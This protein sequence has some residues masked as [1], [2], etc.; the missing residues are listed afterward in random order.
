MPRP[1]MFRAIA[2]ESALAR[3]VEHERTTRG[4]SYEGLAARMTQVGCPLQA[5]AIYK[6]EKGEP[7]RRITVDELAAFALVFEMDLAEMLVMPNDADKARR[8]AEWGQILHHSINSDDALQ[9]LSA[10]WDKVDLGAVGDASQG[11][12]GELWESLRGVEQFAD[13]VRQVDADNSEFRTALD[14]T[15]S[16][17]ARGLLAWRQALLES[18]SV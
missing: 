3:R 18:A 1:N 14:N 7:Q 8:A 17:A 4:M 10:A 9:L 15:I 5:S 11:R 16:R 2:A 12:T 13:I 6:I